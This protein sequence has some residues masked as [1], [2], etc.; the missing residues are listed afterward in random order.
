MSSTILGILKKFG[1]WAVKPT[2]NKLV[3]T[4]NVIFIALFLYSF[5]ETSGQLSYFPAAW[6]I[7]CANVALFYLVDRVGFVKINTIY[8]LRH[9]PELYFKIILPI[10]AALILSGPIVALFIATS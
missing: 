10:Y 9:Q 5:Y 8:E 3:T 6:L 2:M 7:S 4:V 1:N